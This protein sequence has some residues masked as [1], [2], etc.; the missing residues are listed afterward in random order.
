MQ[1]VQV[2][3]RDPLTHLYAPTAM[4]PDMYGLLQVH[5]IG[6]GLGNGEPSPG[7]HTIHDASHDFSRYCPHRADNRQLQR[8]AHSGISIRDDKQ[9]GAAKV[10]HVIQALLLRCCHGASH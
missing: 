2:A 5:Q 9:A 4:K 3:S 7:Q 10:L 6:C 8:P 1:A